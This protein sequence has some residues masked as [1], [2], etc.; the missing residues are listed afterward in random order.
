MIL[1]HALGKD[2]LLKGKYTYDKLVRGRDEL[3]LMRTTDETTGEADA[4]WLGF[5]VFL[6]IIIYIHDCS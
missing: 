3:E 2:K 5:L 1:G 6:Y 4:G